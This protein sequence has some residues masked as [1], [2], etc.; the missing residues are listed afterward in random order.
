MSSYFPGIL[1]EKRVELYCHCVIILVYGLTGNDFLPICS[2][3]DPPPKKNYRNMVIMF[4][5]AVLNIESCLPVLCQ[6]TI[7]CQ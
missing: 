4:I 6:N 7:L 5:I 3:L 1:I 2:T